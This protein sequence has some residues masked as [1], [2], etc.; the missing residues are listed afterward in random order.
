MPLRLSKHKRSPNW[1][2]RGTL[3]GVKVEESTGVTDRKIAETFRAKKEWQII[4]GAIIGRR[5][6]ATFLDAMIGYLED[7]GEARFLKRIVDILGPVPLSQI[8]NTSIR[9]IANQL[10][11]KG[12]PSTVNR[13]IYTPISAVLRH[14]AKRKLCDP[15]LVERPRQPKGRIRWL[16][17]EEAERLIGACAPHLR[18]LVIFL[19]YTGA[20][21][22]E[23]LALD[24]R[25]VDLERRHITFSD[26][27]NGEDRGVPI[28]PRLLVALANLPHRMGA[29]FRRRDGM[30]YTPKDEGGGQIKKGFKGAC[31]RAGIVD[32]SPH[33]CRHTWATWYYAA[34]RDLP[35]LMR[36]GGWKSE[37]MVLRYAHVNVDNLAQ[38]VALLPGAMGR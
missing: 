34:T 28:A 35:A 15:L 23:V 20:R 2:I 12:G 32:F 3:R 36:L 16:T 37:R 21:V 5:I 13:H 6:N 17:A 9:T 22:G 10:Y 18:P 30:P 8:D 27:K 38:S 19:L 33:D 7:G 1:Y 4:Q 14:A 11:P 26:T 24:W 29:V 31:R 25:N